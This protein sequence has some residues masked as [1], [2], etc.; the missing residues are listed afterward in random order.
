MSDTVKP[1]IQIPL[2]RLVD[3]C[4][5][6][7]VTELALFGS[8]L[9]D[10]FRN[11]SD[12]DVLVEFEAG[13]RFGLFRYFELRDELAALLGRN[14]DLVEKQGLKAVIRDDVIASAQVLYA[15]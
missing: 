14:V 10:D 9:R 6:Y 3:I 5:R 15:A 2:D 13:A 7:Y 11:D 4:R 1:R 12:I 8:V